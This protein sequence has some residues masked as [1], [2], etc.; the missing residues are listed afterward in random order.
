MG[1]KLVPLSH[2][3]LRKAAR[4]VN[5]VGSARVKALA[6]DLDVLMHEAGGMGL[7]A[8]QVGIS[9]RIIVVEVP[10]DEFTGVVEQPPFPPTAIINPEIIWESEAW[11][12]YP[13]GCLTLPGIM[14]NV[15][16]PESVL[17]TG[18]GVDGERLTIQGD[19]W[20][21][22]VLQH[23]IDHLEGTLFPDRVE[24]PAE[25]WRVQA[26][27]LT[28]PIWAK[29]PVVEKFLAEHCAEMERSDI[30]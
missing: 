17:V 5:D 18:W 26:V 27:D 15:C 3:A 7:A 14:G 9:E 16:R 2:E 1:L 19:R 10:D 21:A 28:D 4:P 22:R 25:L 13:E 8:P 6:E 20:L 24:D 23:E 11:V 12:K 29:N 30:A